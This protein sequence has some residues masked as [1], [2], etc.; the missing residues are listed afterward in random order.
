[1]A[2][3]CPFPGFLSPVAPIRA[4]VLCWRTNTLC[5][6]RENPERF[7]NWRQ[8]AQPF[9]SGTAGLMEDAENQRRIL[10]VEVKIGDSLVGELF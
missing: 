7:P 2:G 5:G 4:L 6:H 1:M 10:L 8:L 3:G 9:V